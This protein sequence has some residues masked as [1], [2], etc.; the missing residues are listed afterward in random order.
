MSITRI[1]HSSAVKQS[2]V[3]IPCRVATTANI[4]LSGT[5]TVDGIGLS[6]GDRVLVKNQN[7]GSQ[8]GLYVVQSSTWTRTIDAS[9]SVDVYSGILINILEGST[10]GGIIFKLETANPIVLGTTSLTFVSAA[11]GGVTITN[12]VDDYVV[13]ATGVS[14]QLNGE[15]NMRFDGTNLKITGNTEMTGSLS[16]QSKS[17]DIPHPTKEGWRLRYGVLEGPEH[18]VY[19]RGHSKDKVILLPDY[20]VGLITEDSISVQ[21]TPIGSGCVHWVEKVE[22]NK[23]YINCQD[24]EPNYYFM[25][26]AERKDI[27]KVLLEYK[28]IK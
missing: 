14:G 11:S 2:P 17:F 4:T 22:N 24:G 28:P 5:Q 15:P 25:V 21:L 1:I 6:V 16:A 13:T 23:I 3:K 12:N 10:N 27:D 8:N 20:W 18:G 26:N 7:T 9:E 19:F